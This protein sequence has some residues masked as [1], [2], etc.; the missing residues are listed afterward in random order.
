MRKCGLPVWVGFVPLA[1]FYMYHVMIRCHKMLLKTIL[2]IVVDLLV[3]LVVA[4]MGGELGGRLMY[5]CVTYPCFLVFQY[6]CTSARA[7][8]RIFGKSRAFA[9]GLMLLPPVF[10]AVLALGNA[11]SAYLKK[12]D[13]MVA[14]LEDQENMDQANGSRNENGWC[15]PSCETENAFNRISC[16]ACH[17]VRPE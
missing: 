3:L 7:L 12:L 8:A 4:S 1:G 2:V 10:Q 16:T 11:K 9:I 6:Y 15:C 5:I 14:Q 13:E 17:A